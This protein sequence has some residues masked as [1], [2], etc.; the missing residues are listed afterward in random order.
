MDKCD[1]CGRYMPE[2]NKRDI[3][4]FGQVEIAEGTRLGTFK[5]EQRHFTENGCQKLEI[6][7]SISVAQGGVVL[8]KDGDNGERGEEKERVGQRERKRGR[9]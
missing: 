1:K 3:W 4:N 5:V 7:L 6:R 8:D 9:K 2:Q